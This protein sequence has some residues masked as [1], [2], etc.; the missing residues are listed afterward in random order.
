MTSIIRLARRSSLRGIGRNIA[1]VAT[2]LVIGLRREDPSR[3]WERRV[4]LTPQSIRNL[5]ES[6]QVEF[7]V[8]PCSRRIFT[9]AEYVEMGAT[10]DSDL[11]K[12]HIILG[13]KEPRVEEILVD[14]VPLHGIMRPRTYMMFSHTAKGQEYNMPLLDKFLSSKPDNTLLPTLIDY[15]LLTDDQGKRTLAFGFHAGLAGTLLSL[16]TLGQYHLEKFGMATPF[17]YTPLP[18]SMPGL[19]ELRKALRSVGERIQKFGTGEQMGP[20]II[21][22][23]GSGNV[24]CGC[25]SMLDELPV[26]MVRVDELED[27]VLRRTFRGGEASL[28]KV[29]V[30]NPLPGEY[31]MR[32]DEP[33]S[34]SFSRSHYYANPSSY[35]SAF[36]TLIAPYLT[37]LLN[38]AGWAPGFPRLMSDKGLRAGVEKVRQMGLGRFGVVGD[39]S[40]DPY[41]GL[42]F[43]THATTLSE[44]YYKLKVDTHELWIQSVDILPASLPLDASTH[45]SQGL[46][47]L[48]YLEGLIRRYLE[49]I[50]TSARSPV[51]SPALVSQK[52]E[53]TLHRATIAS[54]GQLFGRFASVQ[55]GGLAGKV[56]AYRAGLLAHASA[57]ASS[58]GK[59]GFGFVSGYESNSQHVSQTRSMSSGSATNPTSSSLIPPTPRTPKKRILLLGSGMVAG[60]AVLFMGRRPDVDLLIASND[61]GELEALAHSQGYKMENSKA[62]SGIEF[63]QVDVGDESQRNE[64]GEVREMIRGVDV[65]ISLLPVSLHVRIAELCIEEGKHLVTASYISPEMRAL[66]DRAIAANVLLLNEIGLDPGI[67]HCSAISLLERIKSESGG[68]KQI[69][70]FVSFCG[71]LPAPDL[72]QGDLDRHGYPSAGP[73]LYKFSWSPRGVLTAALNGAR[74]RLGGEEVVVPGVGIDAPSS[75]STGGVVHDERLK[76]M[77]GMLEGLPNRNSVPYA[78]MYGLQSQDM[79]TLL[80]GTLRYKGFSSLLSFFHQMGMMQTSPSIHFDFLDTTDPNDDDKGANLE[81]AWLNYYEKVSQIPIDRVL[82]ETSPFAKFVDMKLLP[83]YDSD[84]VDA[85]KFNHEHAKALGWLLD[86]RTG[87]KMNIQKGQRWWGLPALDPIHCAPLDLFAKLLAHKLRYGKNERDMCE[88]SEDEEIHTSSLVVYG[89][90]YSSAMARSVGIPVAIAALAVLDGAVEPL[91]SAI[92][93]RGVHGP[94]HAS[95]RECVLKG[96]EQAD[97]GMKEGVRRVKVGD[98]SSLEAKLVAG[99]Q[100]RARAM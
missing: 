92:P 11:S 56:E 66:N 76:A 67:D 36:P 81:E 100:R 24:A 13:I 90:G 70:S 38:G 20:C 21:G 7:H 3:I 46:V 22:V 74:Y 88:D 37:L 10:I 94:G 48:G 62:E 28:K 95:I 54:S 2:P 26:E 4:P 77:T 12:A 16:H 34:Q 73:L 78:D 14:P 89:S 72:L 51:N 47:G 44:P 52:V 17:L 15:E 99:R 91:Y 98:G 8:Q 5:V 80:R 96:M 97:I 85:Y 71:G 25:L 84:K 30:V 53:D 33:K 45:F 32:I 83:G 40:C 29:Y 9:D 31:L 23:T 19:Q 79:R 43:L 42:E 59:P 63:R 50:S 27:L 86:S 82:F 6:G 35:D 69:K 49:P 39:I 57:N 87:T 61:G 55:D 64:G 75:N 65:V 58:A 18:Q 93:I 41:G 1:T 68:K 60:P